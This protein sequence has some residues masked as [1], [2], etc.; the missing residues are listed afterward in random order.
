MKLQFEDGDIIDFKEDIDLEDIL[1]VADYLRLNKREDLALDIDTLEV[2][3]MLFKC[4]YYY[5]YK[6]KTKELN[7]KGVLQDAI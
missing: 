7:N 6:I 2:I 5:G 4:G 1:I 3:T